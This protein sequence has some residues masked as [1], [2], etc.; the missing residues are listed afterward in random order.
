MKDR[1]ALALA[2]TQPRLLQTVKVDQHFQVVHYSGHWVLNLPASVKGMALVCSAALAS[3]AAWNVR[4]LLAALAA[5]VVGV[6]DRV[7]LVRLRLNE[8]SAPVE[9]TIHAAG[10]VTLSSY[11]SPVTYVEGIAITDNTPDMGGAMA[12][13]CSSSPVLPSGLKLDPTTCKIW[14]KPSAPFPKAIY[15]ITAAKSA[16]ESKGSLL[17]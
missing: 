6:S 1:S 17:A 4:V 8:R 11:T 7:R 16:N 13:G 10:P 5:V 15:Q 3:V 9:I 12:T 14:G 2:E